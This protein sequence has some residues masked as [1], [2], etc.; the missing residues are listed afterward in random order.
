MA[1]KWK[2]LISRSNTKR[3]GHSNVPL[4]ALAQGNKLMRKPL[5][6]GAIVLMNVG[7]ALTIILAAVLT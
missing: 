4:S 5:I 2:R 3:Q 7:Y 1:R 6:L